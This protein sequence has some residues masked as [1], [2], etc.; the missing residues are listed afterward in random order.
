MR[1]ATVILP[2]GP[3]SA[4]L[5]ARTAA[6]ISALPPSGTRPITLLSSGVRF[7]QNLPVEPS[8]NAPSMKWAASRRALSKLT[9]VFLKA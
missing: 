4:A 1:S 8:V 2:Q 5:A 7:S 6:S 9:D 3:E